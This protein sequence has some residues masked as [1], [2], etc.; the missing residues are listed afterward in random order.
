MP[1]TK[2]A[3]LTVGV[4]NDLIA[5]DGVVCKFRIC[6]NARIREEEESAL[7]AA[8]PLPRPSAWSRVS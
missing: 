1:R 2:G 4:V 3:F 6:S 8:A 7:L 5:Y